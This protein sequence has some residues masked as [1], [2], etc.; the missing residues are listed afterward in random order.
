VYYVEDPK[1]PNWVVVVKTKP[2]NVYDVG[3]GESKDY[4]EADSYHEHEPF[5]INVMGDVGLMT[6]ID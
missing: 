6:S 4:A 5:N 1:I 3:N 2:R